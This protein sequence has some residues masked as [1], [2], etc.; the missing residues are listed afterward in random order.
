MHRTDPASGKRKKSNRVYFIILRLIWFRLIHVLDEGHE[1]ALILYG[2]DAQATQRPDT[3]TTITV[4]QASIH[5]MVP[6]VR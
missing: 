4:D 3:V 6:I 1:L 2:I 5:A